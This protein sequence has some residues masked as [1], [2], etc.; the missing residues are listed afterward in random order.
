MRFQHTIFCGVCLTA[1]IGLG[2]G[3][4]NKYQDIPVYQPATQPLTNTGL[5]DAQGVEA[6]HAVV[7]PP[8]GW[9][10]EPVKE[11]DGSVHYT[12][13]SP[14]GNTAFGVIHF[15]MPLPVP[16]W[17][18]YPNI[19]QK[20]KE[21]EGEANVIEGPLKDESLPGMRFTVESGDYRMRTNLITKGFRGWMIYAGTMRDRTEDP[22]ELELAEKSRDKTQV[23]TAQVAEQA[24]VISPGVLASE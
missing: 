21:H 8:V 7:K 2:A 11:T 24:K 20:M 3:C 6:V 23:G 12:W 15:G 1:F 10:L 5:A 17:V 18:V 13:K 4:Q 14:T 19:I 9:Q 22:A 16:T